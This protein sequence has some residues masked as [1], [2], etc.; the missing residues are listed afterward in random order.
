MGAKAS[1]SVGYYFST[2]ATLD[3]ANQLL[4]LQF[5]GQL[6]PKFPSSRFGTAAVPPGVVPGTHFILFVADYQNQVGEIDE[7][8]SVRAVSFTVSSL[9]ADLVIT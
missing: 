2:D 1:S 5:G 8:N 4:A 9:G 6:S 7:N 3:A